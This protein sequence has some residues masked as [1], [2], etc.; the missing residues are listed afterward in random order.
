MILKIKL[1]VM[2]LVSLLFLLLS[3]GVFA[4]DERFF[5]KIF[6]D[7]FIKKSDQAKKT[8]G[9]WQVISP[10]YQFDIDSNG[11]NESIITEKN[12]GEDWLHIYGLHG[13][14]IYSGKLEAKGLD[15]HLYKI[16]IRKLSSKSKVLIL[17]FYEGHHSY[18]DSIASARLFFLTLD[19]N[20]FKTLSLYKGPRFWEEHKSAEGYYHR[21]GMKLSLYDYNGDG[22]RDISVKHQFINRVYYYRGRGRWHSL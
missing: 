13:Q 20:D 2:K 5:R 14:H 12:D 22:L 9:K 19:N 3:N 17:H 11:H 16:S 6:A 7:D 15:S 18:L 1:V 8:K 10:A 4:Q 21:R